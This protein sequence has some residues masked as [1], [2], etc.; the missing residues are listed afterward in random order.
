MNKGMKETE[1]RDGVAGGVN[2]RISKEEERI[3]PRCNSSSLVPWPQQ[4]PGLNHTLL[5]ARPDRSFLAD[6]REPKPVALSSQLAR[7][8][9]IPNIFHSTM[10]HHRQVHDPASFIFHKVRVY[11]NRSSTYHSV[12][13]LYFN[14]YF[15]SSLGDRIKPSLGNVRVG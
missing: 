6:V 4:E 14:T 10:S 8:T 13:F 1:E 12:L 7:T 9:N 2:K 5:Q 15:L 11:H 3:P